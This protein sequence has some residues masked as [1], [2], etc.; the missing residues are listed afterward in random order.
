MERVI[1]DTESGRV[2]AELLRRGIAADTRVRVLVEVRDAE[3]ISTAA[4]A[5][6]GVRSTGL[7]TSPISTPTLI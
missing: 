6:A 2:C 4:I 1:L 5:Q 3:E 7:Q